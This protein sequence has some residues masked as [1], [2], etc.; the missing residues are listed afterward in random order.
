MKLRVFVL[1][2]AAL[3]LLSMTADKPAYMIF[4]V[5]GKKSS[6]KNLLKD[7]LSS[8]VILFGELHNNPIS[9][10]MELQLT[11]DLYKERKQDLV[12]GAEMFEADNQEALNLYLEGKIS[13]DSLKKAVRLWPNYATDYKSLVEFARNTSLKFIASNVP[14]NIA[15]MVYK[16][17]F[18]VLN[19]LSDEQKS[20]VA[21]LPVEYDPELEQYKKML[22]MNMAGHVSPNLPR[23]QALKDATMAHFIL[24]HLENGKIVLHFNG[25]YH[26]DYFEGIMWYLKRANPY[27]RVMTIAT[28]EQGNIEKLSAEY[29]MIAD[30]ILCVP[31]DMTKTY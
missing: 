5:K 3:L 10:W 4:D 9:H 25:T 7:A 29:I 30:Y 13:E 14:R 26:S 18:D 31:E 1:M 8:D 11:K 12:L 28:V 22:E 16:G 17:G 23:S 6:Y 15:N 19:E 27:L 2:A 24:K 20:W 21:P